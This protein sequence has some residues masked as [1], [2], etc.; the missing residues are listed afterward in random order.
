ML[1]NND[2]QWVEDDAALRELVTNYYKELFTE[3]NDRRI[4]FN[5]KYGFKPLEEEVASKLER[6]VEN[7]E[8]KIALFD[9]GAWKAPGPDGYPAGFYQKNW[10][11]VGIKLNEFV[12]QVWQQPDSIS[13]INNTD[14]CLIPKVDKPEFVSQF[15]PISL[16]NVSYKVLTKVIVNRLKPLIPNIISPYQ[17]GFIPTRSIHENIVVAQEMVHSMSKMRGRNGYVAV[18][19]DLAK[20]YDRIRWSF[21]SAVLEEVNIPAGLRT[22]IMH[23]I[24][25][26]K[27]N[28]MWHGNRSIFFQPGKG[29]RQGDPMSPYIFVLCMDK[30]SHLI[31]EAVDGGNWQPIK[32]GRSG[33]F[34]SH[35]MFADDLLLFGKATEVNMRTITDTLEKFCELS[36]QLVSIEKTSVLFSKNVPRDLRNVLLLQ[37]GFRE[38]N[39]L[40]KYLG[41][42][43][44][45]RAPR[46][47]DFE[48]L[49]DKVRRK[50]SGWKATNLSFAG[51]VTLA[52]SVIQ[53]VPIYSM[54]TTPIPKRVLMDIHRIQ[55]NFIW[56]HDTSQRKMHMISWGTL[57]L[58]KES[59]GLA[60]RHLPTMNTAC[61]MKMGWNMRENNG[62][63][64]CNVL[65]GKYG[66]ARGVHGNFVVKPTDSFIW[67]GIVKAWGN[68]SLYEEW[69][70]GNGTS[71]LAWRDKWLGE[72]IVLGQT[73]EIIPENIANWKVADMVN[74]LGEWK[75]EVLNALLLL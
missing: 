34:I 75:L 54:M 71:V 21:I 28:V 69:S 23:C 6:E 65:Q 32:A 58:P 48:H 52:K 4:T 15:R 68:I 41:I 33:P 36:G 60:I 5:M 50:L 22:I 70:V 44:V 8:I 55:R 37:S 56:G 49:V 16:C 9:M 18:K 12:R 13:N 35:L 51:R 45:G 72:N 3:T 27:T 14:I 10:S 73:M 42:P 63:L 31:A 66:R 57:L 74:E 53:A 64:W 24:T 20:A 40:G 59:G 30:L 67:K 19:V 26:V 2:G 29:I 47:S 38:A 43:L 25:S 61:L 11:I 46:H 62:S 17:T 1:R 7:D 39:S